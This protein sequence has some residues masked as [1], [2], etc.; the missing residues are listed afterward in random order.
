MFKFFGRDK[1][2]IRTTIVVSNDKCRSV[3]FWSKQIDQKKLFVLSSFLRDKLSNLTH[4][5]PLQL[6]LEANEQR[7]CLWITRFFYVD[8]GINFVSTKAFKL[9]KL[10][11]VIKLYKS[12]IV[13]VRT[14]QQGWCLFYHSKSAHK[15]RLF[16]LIPYLRNE[17]RCCR[18][19]ADAQKRLVGIA[20]R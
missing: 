15:Q 7:R 8:H 1:V 3:T 10:R 19:A 5:S 16:W 13:A 18:K 12:V 20:I 4:I 2:S 14:P 11:I 6:G 17:Q 9:Y